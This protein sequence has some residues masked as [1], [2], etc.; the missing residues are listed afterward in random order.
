MW[1]LK[2]LKLYQ[3][4]IWG[5]VR[6]QGEKVQKVWRQTRKQW[7]LSYPQRELRNR[8]AE[9]ASTC[10]FV[11]FRRC[12][13]QLA[14]ENKDSWKWGDITWHSSCL[15][16]L[17]GFLTHEEWMLKQT[18]TENWLF[19]S[20]LTTISDHLSPFWDSSFVIRTQQGLFIIWGKPRKHKMQWNII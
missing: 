17:R 13:T 7:L 8:N 15:G 1:H 4:L 19:F 14:K 3:V 5:T 6:A 9:V 11:V 2:G 20:K 18:S 12:W 10:Q 16:S